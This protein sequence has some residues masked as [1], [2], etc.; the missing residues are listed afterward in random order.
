MLMKPK[1]SI[2]LLI[3]SK[4][5]H[6]EHAPLSDHGGEEDN[7]I[8]LHSAAEEMMNA[9]HS[10]D[11]KAMSSALQNF[12][13]MHESQEKEPSSETEGVEPDAKQPDNA[14]GYVASREE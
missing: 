7:K 5:S 4:G 11:H 13:D 1:K 12:L 3:A 6:S 2:A 10:K 9:I 14:S 8:G